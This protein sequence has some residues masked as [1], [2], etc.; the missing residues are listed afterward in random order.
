[1]TKTSE[2]KSDT[3]FICKQSQQIKA[4]TNHSLSL[5]PNDLQI[6]LTHLR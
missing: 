5:Y 2:H 6:L 1:M 3:V 4:N